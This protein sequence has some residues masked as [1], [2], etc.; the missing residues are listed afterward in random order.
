[1][2][3]IFKNQIKIQSLKWTRAS[4]ETDDDALS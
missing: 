1:V 3:T 4:E 2:P